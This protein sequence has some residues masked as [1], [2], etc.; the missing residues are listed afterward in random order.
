M[1]TA[2]IQKISMDETFEDV[3]GLILNRVRKF[4]D[5][6]GG[7]SDLG[8]DDCVSE[9]YWAFLEAG[10]WTGKQK[11]TWRPHRNK[12][13]S[14]W[15]ASKVD[16]KLLDLRKKTAQRYAR[17]DQPIIEDLPSPKTESPSITEDDLSSGARDVL[18]VICC[19]G[20]DF[21]RGVED[22]QKLAWRTLRD[23]GWSSEELADA[24]DEL[25]QMWS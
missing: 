13:F 17:N 11:G 8:W 18:D 23:L 16:W 14:S 9:G 2:T 19:L 5:R 22:K 7:S 15:I 6:H 4:Y 20:V 12:K 3:R 10:G 25:A 1:T 24:F 21:F